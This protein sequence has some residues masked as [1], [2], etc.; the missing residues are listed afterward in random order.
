MSIS[1]KALAASRPPLQNDMP[2]RERPISEL[3]RIV[4]KQWAAA[5]AAARYLDDMSS[6]VKSQIFLTITDTSVA[7]AE[8]MARAHPDY[9]EHLETVRAAREKANLLF[10]Q[11]KYYEIKHSEWQSD[12][13]NQRKERGMGRQAT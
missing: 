3:Y 7:R 4:A 12:E 6:T 11:K 1:E 13:A 5:D 8:H 2:E 9:I 10:G